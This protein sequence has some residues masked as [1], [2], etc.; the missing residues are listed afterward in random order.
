MALRPPPSK[1]A[2]PAPTPEELA[3]ATAAAAKTL[4]QHVDTWLRGQ[5]LAEPRPIDVSIGERGRIPAGVQSALCGLYKAAG[6]SQ[7]TTTQDL[8]A[9]LTETVDGAT[10]E[11]DAGGVTWNGEEWIYEGA[12]GVQYA[13]ATDP[14]FTF[15]TKPDPRGIVLHLVP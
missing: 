6:W 12:G 4:E 15:T 11:L 13:V 8:P 2:K 1:P 7:A 3:A 10:T 14:L 9:S 5:R